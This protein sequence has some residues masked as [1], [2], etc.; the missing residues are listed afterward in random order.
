MKALLYGAYGYTAQLILT[1]SDQLPWQWVLA[2]RNEEA[3]KPIAEK[4][5]CEYRVFDLSNHAHICRELDDVQWVLHCA[6]P[7]VHTAKP[8]M[9][10]CIEK[11][12]HYSDITGE[13]EVFEWAANFSDQAQ[14]ANIML[15]PGCGFDVV[16]TD[17]M[18]K[19]LA[20]KMPDAEEL[21]LA[22]SGGGG[23]SKG[24]LKSAFNKLGKSGKERIHHK[25]TDVPIAYK[26]LRFSW[27]Q[28][29]YQG[30]SIPWGDV[31]TAWYSTGIPNITTYMLMKKGVNILPLI[32]RLIS[33]LLKIQA[34]RSSILNYMLNK[35]SDGPGKEELEQ[36]R[37]LVWGRVAKDKR[38]LEGILRGP[39]AYKL[40]ALSCLAIGRRI[41][42]G[43]WKAGFQTPSMAYG[44]DLL[45]DI[46]GFELEIR[47]I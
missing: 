41:F 44:T 24:T 47:E 18:A 40:T 34:I 10:A 42:L 8:M 13:F 38:S 22:F 25:L 33:P 1:Y 11:G 5:G 7:F 39:H 46:P 9:E 2:G 37:S 21:W 23:M 14:A 4:Y 32:I 43:D 45:N 31:F 28:K 30:I 27:N 6:G 3:L 12:V 16:P 26:T 35:A 29:Q 17:L 19:A 15:M 36:K 20:E